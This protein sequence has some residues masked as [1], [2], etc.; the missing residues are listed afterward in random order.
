[1]A[2]RLE[3]DI[4]ADIGFVVSPWTHY[5]SGARDVRIG[6]VKKLVRVIRK[7]HNNTGLVSSPDSQLCEM[8]ADIALSK[9]TDD[10]S[11][12]NTWDAASVVIEA[13]VDVA[14]NPSGKDNRFLRT[15]EYLQQTYGVGV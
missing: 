3:S 7:Y 10:K 1:M 5:G 2:T 14:R 11:V 4:M 8:V 13:H 6:A 9:E 12:A 15:M